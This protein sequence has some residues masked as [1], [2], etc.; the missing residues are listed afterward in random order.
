MRPIVVPGTVNEECT[1]KS[2]KPREMGGQR[3]AKM[4]GTGQLPH[5][6]PK[7]VLVAISTFWCSGT[8]TRLKTDNQLR[9]NEPTATKY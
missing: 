2:G 8:D 6:N 3:I 5:P 1:L 7:A 9:I 4:S